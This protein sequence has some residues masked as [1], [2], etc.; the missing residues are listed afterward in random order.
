MNECCLIADWTMQRMLWRWREMWGSDAVG[1]QQGRLLL[2]LFS[3]LA[4]MERFDDRS[5]RW[6]R[7][8]IRQDPHQLHSSN[9]F[10]S[11]IFSISNSILSNGLFREGR[12]RGRDSPQRNRSSSNPEWDSKYQSGERKRQIKFYNLQRNWL[13]SHTTATLFAIRL[14][15]SFL[16]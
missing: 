2:W 1:Y 14:K 13:D 6:I 8:T 4:T 7:P 11:F 5:G 16:F 9:H 12:G 15:R 3:V 10:T